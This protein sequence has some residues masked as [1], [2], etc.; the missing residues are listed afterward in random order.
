[1]KD[2]NRE[3]EIMILKLKNKPKLISE[4]LTIFLLIDNYNRQ[5]LQSN[6]YF[7]NEVVRIQEM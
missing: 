2:V 7:L 1:M 4:I 5:K 6:F 3:K